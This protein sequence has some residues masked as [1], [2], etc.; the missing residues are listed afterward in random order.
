MSN[1]ALVGR[2]T[3]EFTNRNNF[4]VA[5]HAPDQACRQSDSTHV[6]IL[7]RTGQMTGSNP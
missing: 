4:A 7:P 2:F 6:R 1:D 5:G 3:G